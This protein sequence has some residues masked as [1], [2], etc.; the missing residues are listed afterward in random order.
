MESQHGKSFRAALHQ[1]AIELQPRGMEA[2]STLE[3]VVLVWARKDVGDWR[4]GT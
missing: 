2:T 3:A 1:S 4:Q